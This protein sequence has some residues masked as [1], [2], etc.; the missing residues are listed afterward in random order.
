MI[1]HRSL[2]STKTC[3][4]S[5]YDVCMLMQVVVEEVVTQQ[6]L[7]YT[8]PENTDALVAARKAIAAWSLPRAAA[9]LKAAKQ[10]Q[11][12]GIGTY[13]VSCMTVGG[14]VGAGIT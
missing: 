5:L 14:E 8:E 10:Q 6:E 13:K 1:Q 9:R 11:A 4:C 12:G 3:T 7:F 2:T